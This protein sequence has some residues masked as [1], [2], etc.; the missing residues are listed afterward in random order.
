MNGYWRYLGLSALLT[1]ILAGAVGGCGTDA[2]ELGR[3]EP[4]NVDVPG[5]ASPGSEAVSQE[6]RETYA[7]GSVDGPVEN[8]GLWQGRFDGKQL[9][10]EPVD[11]VA[12]NSGVRPQA[13]VPLNESRLTVTTE[14]AIV[15]NS[16]CEGGPD[17]FTDDNPHLL[18]A[19]GQNCTAHQMCASV[20]L[21]NTSSRQIDRPFIEILEITNSVGANSV[22]VPTGYPLSNAR[23]LWSYPNLPINGGARAHMAFALSNCNDF[24]F[25]ARITGTLRPPQFS[26]ETGGLTSFTNACTLGGTITNGGAPA[27]AFAVPFP[28]SLYNFTFD[29]TL[30]VLRVSASGALGLSV[31]GTTNANLPATGRDY[32]I[33]PFWDDITMASGRVCTHS[34]G[35]LGSRRLV[36]T[37]ENAMFNASVGPAAP[38][39]PFSFS[40]I[41]HEGT[42]QITFE[43]NTCDFDYYFQGGSAT[44]GVQGIAALGLSSQLVGEVPFPPLDYICMG[45]EIGRRVTF[46][47]TQPPILP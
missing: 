10:F 32:S 13:H 23:G 40:A 20:F 47:P 21:R 17:Y 33:L 31:A 4:V 19:T 15:V 6:K 22:A 42:D 16:G 12:R 18:A 43:Y 8:L 29:G 9:T 35:A 5:S 7:A 26:A 39:T 2:S 41:L 28:F 44:I 11:S 3:Q 25:L 34:S 38:A 30:P 24:S 45:D 46:N 14:Q 37:C 27:A 36:V 1:P